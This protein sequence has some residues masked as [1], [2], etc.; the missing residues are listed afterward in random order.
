MK[1]F[2]EIA[3]LLVLCNPIFEQFGMFRDEFLTEYNDYRLESMEIPIK[4]GF[5]VSSKVEYQTHDNTPKDKATTPLK[6]KVQG[7]YE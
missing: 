3:R 2:F 4:L 5:S 7:Y 6:S 1:D